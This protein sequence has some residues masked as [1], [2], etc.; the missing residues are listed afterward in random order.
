MSRPCADV[1]VAV[2]DFVAEKPLPGCAIRMKMRIPQLS[3]SHEALG[4]RFDSG[5]LEMPA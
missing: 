1:R 2:L 3:S 4:R 5:P